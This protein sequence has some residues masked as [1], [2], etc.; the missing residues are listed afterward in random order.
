MQDLFL[1][2]RLKEILHNTSVQQETRLL[3]RL[4]LFQFSDEQCSL[5]FSDMESETLLPQCAKVIFVLSF[6]HDRNR[7]RNNACVRFGVC[8]ARGSGVTAENSG[9]L[10]SNDIREAFSVLCIT[11]LG[12]MS[13]LKP[14]L[15][16]TDHEF[17]HLMSLQ[18]EVCC[19]SFII[20][21]RTQAKNNEPFTW[22]EIS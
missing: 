15:I 5:S 4:L 16:T 13:L 7:K 3:R 2:T 10:E 11:G 19:L 12:F 22:T 8:F 20:Y 21:N 18:C 17:L 14:Q 9:E 6:R 1:I